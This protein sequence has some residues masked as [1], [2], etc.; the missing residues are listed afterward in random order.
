M[1]HPVMLPFGACSLP[2]LPQ[3]TQAWRG[4]VVKERPSIYYGNAN[5]GGKPKEKKTQKA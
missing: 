2:S 3:M 1:K 4:R 5:V